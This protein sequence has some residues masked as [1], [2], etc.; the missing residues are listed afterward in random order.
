M[1]NLVEMGLVCIGGCRQQKQARAQAER[2]TCCKAVEV[3][4]DI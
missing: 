1:A 4:Q 3:F 2:G